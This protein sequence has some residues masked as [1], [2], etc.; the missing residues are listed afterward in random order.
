VFDAHAHLDQVPSNSDVSGWIV[1][2][3]TL[4]DEELLSHLSQ[5]PRVF[6]ALGLHPW[7]LPED[8]SALHDLLEHLE[9]VLAN[10]PVIAIGETGLDKG[11]RAGAM[12]LQ[13]SAFQAQIRLAQ[14][15]ELPLIIHCV[16]TH[17]ACIQT[18]RDEG[19]TGVGMVHDYSGPLEMIPRWIEAGF[20]LS[21]S[22]RGMNRTEVIKEIPSKRLLI[23]TDEASPESLHEVCRNVAKAR[24]MTPTS[25]G[26]L[27]ESNLRQLMN[28]AQD[29]TTPETRTR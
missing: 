23:E 17:G 4:H 18:L 3:V 5:D 20:W 24:T 13:K 6:T 16:R 11:P 9:H 15:H 2:G 29:K 14:K 7:Y 28:L 10:R 27:T 1:P 25:V 19:F 26:D 12:Q 8:P 21:I 22:P